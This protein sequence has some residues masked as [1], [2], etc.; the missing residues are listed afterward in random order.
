MTFTAKIDL[1]HQTNI[2]IWFLDP[3]IP[4]KV[5]SY[6][7]L[8]FFVF[9]VNL[10]IYYFIFDPWAEI[11]QEYI[12]QKSAVVLGPYNLSKKSYGDN[13]LGGGTKVI[14]APGL[15]WNII[16]IWLKFYFGFKFT[17]YV[18]HCKKS[19]QKYLLNLLWIL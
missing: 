13:S 7:I 1:F 11:A 6:I 3:K 2:F 8:A 17:W 12:S 14:L 19:L 5:V 9:L 4:L 18:F 15:L 16:N 10:I